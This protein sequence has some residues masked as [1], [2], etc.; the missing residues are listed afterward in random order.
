MADIVVTVPKSFGLAAWIDE[1]DA[2][3]EPWSG[4]DWVYTT[5][6]PRPQ[7]A[8]GDRVYIVCCG[9]LR[10][11]APLVELTWDGKL[12]GNKAPRWGRL[13]F[14]RRGDAVAVTLPAGVTGFMGWRYRWWDR[15]VELPFPNWREVDGKAPAATAATAA[16]A[17]TARPGVSM[18][19]KITCTWEA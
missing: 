2:A 5:F 17:A 11:Y 19:E 8:P 1:G 12:F 6:G 3:G 9:L 7:I 16:P 13:G 4:E 14:V 10:G 15:A 18:F